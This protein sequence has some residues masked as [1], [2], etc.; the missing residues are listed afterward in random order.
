MGLMYCFGSCVAVINISF[1][2][3]QAKFVARASC[4]ALSFK[5]CRK[6]FDITAIVL[7]QSDLSFPK[8]ACDCQK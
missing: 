7:N 1:I 3:Q 2:R 5:H 4:I 6:A 8:Y